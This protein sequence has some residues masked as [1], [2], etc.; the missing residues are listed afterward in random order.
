MLGDVGEACRERSVPPKRQ[1]S[2]GRLEH[3]SRLSYKTILTIL[4]QFKTVATVSMQLK[5][6][7]ASVCPLDSTLAKGCENF[8]RPATHAL[9]RQSDKPVATV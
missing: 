9:F 4:E 3:R 6:I 2:H 1:A 8:V 7:K 5:E